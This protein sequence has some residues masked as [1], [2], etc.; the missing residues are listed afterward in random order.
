MFGLYTKPRFPNYQWLFNQL[1]MNQCFGCSKIINP[2]Q[3][4][5]SLLK[6]YAW[7]KWTTNAVFIFN[8]NPLSV[9]AIFNPIGSFS[10]T[11]SKPI[12]CKRIYSIFGGVAFKDRDWP[13]PW[14]YFEITKNN[15]EIKLNPNQLWFVLN[16]IF[17]LEKSFVHPC[18][19]GLTFDPNTLNATCMKIYFFGNILKWF[20]YFRARFEVQ[21]AR[22]IFINR[23][24]FCL[25]WN[26]KHLRMFL[27]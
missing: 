26:Y 4:L 19:K 20:T 24:V 17:Q 10:H 15:L 11:D 7:V 22:S 2:G 16:N 18:R 9:P 25:S 8:R 5:K 14:N 23:Q 6:N 27:P 21:F 12:C 13:V 3:D 1:P